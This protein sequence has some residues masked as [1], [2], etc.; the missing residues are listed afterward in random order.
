MKSEL[1]ASKARRI[2]TPAPHLSKLHLHNPKKA[3]HG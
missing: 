1:S 3:L 2:A